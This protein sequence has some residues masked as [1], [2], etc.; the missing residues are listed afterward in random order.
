K[1][2][3]KPIFPILPSAL[4]AAEEVSHFHSMGHVNFTDEV[5]FGYVLSRVNRVHQ[6]YDDAELPAVDI[7]RIRSVIDGAGEGYLSPDQVFQ[8]L[9]AAGIATVRQETVTTVEQALKHAAASGFPL[10]MKVSGPVHK[11]DVGGVVVGVNS[12][13]EVELI[14]RRLMQIPGADGV[15]IQQQLTGTEVYIGAKQEDRFGHQ[16][17]CGLGGIFIEVFKDVAAGLAPVGKAEARSMIRHLRSYPIIRGV[18]G[19]AGI[20]EDLLT[21]AITR[22]GALVTAAPEIAEMD[23]NPLMGNMQSLVAVDARIRVSKAISDSSH[24]FCR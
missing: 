13:E 14:F 12:A 22:V 20:S 5:S 2:C 11:S 23:I 8:L 7:T 16:V 6:P 19:K 21:E 15:L 4:Q 17:V 10:V 3:K 18:R 24:P 1:T 9:D